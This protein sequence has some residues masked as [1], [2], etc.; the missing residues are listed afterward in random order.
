[1]FDFGSSF[2][3]GAKEVIACVVRRKLLLCG[4]RGESY[5]EDVTSS[6]KLEI[7]SS[8]GN[9]SLEFLS[10]FL[11]LFLFTV[12]IKSF[13]FLSNFDIFAPQLWMLMCIILF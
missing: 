3:C 8:R 12:F 2:L 1:M 4:A 13:D 7:S 6:L 10:I 11:L 9:L 5:Q